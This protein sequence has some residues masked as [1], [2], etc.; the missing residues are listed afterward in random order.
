MV[1]EV[2]GSSSRRGLMVG[3]GSA[4][5][6]GGNVCVV[7]ERGGGLGWEV[8]SSQQ[9]LMV[10]SMDTTTHMCD[11]CDTVDMM[12]CD[13]CATAD[14]GGTVDTRDELLAHTSARRIAT[15]SSTRNAPAESRQ[16]PVGRYHPSQ[17]HPTCAASTTAAGSGATDG[18][19]GS[20][21]PQPSADVSSNTAGVGLQ[22]M[23][24][25]CSGDSSSP[26]DP[27]QPHA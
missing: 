26:G 9:A 21:P 11:T 22:N 20:S 18:S 12:I 17:L 7:G 15:S 14:T 4:P 10:N 16:L 5:A 2:E 23:T 24:T 8:T 3:Q 1:V 27:A 25:E 19:S 13:T 6:H